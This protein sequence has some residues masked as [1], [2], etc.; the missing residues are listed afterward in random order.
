M[1]KNDNSYNGSYVKIR[2]PAHGLAQKQTTYLGEGSFKLP[3]VP[4][5]LMGMPYAFNTPK[6]F[7]MP[8]I[9]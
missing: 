9:I 1:D 6:Q 7:T 5:D 8:K 3:S 4:S 2:P